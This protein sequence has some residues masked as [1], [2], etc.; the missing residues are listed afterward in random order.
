GAK[1]QPVRV[2]GQCGGTDADITAAVKWAAGVPVPGVPANPTPA[3]VI[4]L[5][6]GGYGTC[7]PAWNEAIAA[8]K[9][10]GAAVVV[11]LGNEGMDA[12]DS[13]PANCNGVI[14]VAATSDYGDR[15][16]Y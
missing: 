12:T 13:V 9:G 16:G 6:L 14:G 5:S 8:A 10:A 15:A 1:I 4:N 2:L 3:K 11:A 7:T